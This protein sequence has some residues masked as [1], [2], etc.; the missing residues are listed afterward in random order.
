MHFLERIYTTLAKLRNWFFTFLV[1]P[2]F[3]SIGKGS[4]IV[5]PF[6]FKNA[7]RISIGSHVMIHQGCWIQ[8]LPS[9]SGEQ[10]ISIGDGTKIGMGSSIIGQKNVTIEKNVLIARNVY[11]SDHS[12][13]YSDKS[14]PIHAQGIRKIRPIIIREGAWIGHGAVILPGCEVGKNSV[15]GANTVVNKTVPCYAIA[16]GVPARIIYCKRNTLPQ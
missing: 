1:A 8:A 7:H 6:R 15:V 10:T 16:V 12:H 11:I 5:P 13:A 14:M 2:C 4:R 9:E 3:A